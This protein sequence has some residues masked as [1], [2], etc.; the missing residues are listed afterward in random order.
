[1]PRNQFLTNAH[2]IQRFFQSHQGLGVR[3]RA[4]IIALR[5]NMDKGSKAWRAF[6]GLGPVLS[7]Q[8]ENMLDP[9]EYGVF[10]WNAT[11]PEIP[12]YIDVTP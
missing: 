9:E 2:R 4:D 12:W 1:M 10:E 5:D 11:M 8:L 6:N 3:T 7:A